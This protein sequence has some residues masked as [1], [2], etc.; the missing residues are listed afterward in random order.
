MIKLQ[1]KAIK[2]SQCQNHN[3]GKYRGGIIKLCKIVTSWISQGIVEFLWGKNVIKHY[4]A[5]SPC[6]M[7]LNHK[8]LNYLLRNCNDILMEN[9]RLVKQYSVMLKIRLSSNSHN[10]DIRLQE[11]SM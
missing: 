6:C 8:Y 1:H 11:I 5:Y 10:S 4:N 3:Y 9:R 2:T 7:V